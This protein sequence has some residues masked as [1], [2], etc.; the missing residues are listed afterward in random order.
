MLW[1]CVVMCVMTVY[2]HVCYGTLQPCVLWHCVLTCVMAPYIHVCYDT[3]YS[4]VLWHRI[5]MCVMAPY[6]L[7]CY[8]TAL[9]SGTLICQTYFSCPVSFLHFSNKRPLFQ[10]GLHFEERSRRFLRPVDVHISTAVCHNPENHS[11]NKAFFVL[12]YL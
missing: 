6:R 2:S 11:V 10:F 1:H 3:V 9:P 12:A 5:A 4:C 7:E 8:G